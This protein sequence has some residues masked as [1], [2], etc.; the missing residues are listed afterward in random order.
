MKVIIKAI[1]TYLPPDVEDGNTL[2]RDN[3][4]WCIGDIEEKTGIFLRHISGP[5]ETTTD[6]AEFAAEKL[7]K[8]GVLKEDI[9]SLILV[10]QSPDYALPS[11]ACILQNRLGLRKSCIAFDVNLGCSGFVYGL[12]ILGSMIEGGL[13]KKGLIVCSERYT[14]YIGKSDRT[15]RPL[16]SDASSAT[17]LVSS[18]RDMIGPF[19]MGTDGSGFQNLI[20]PSSDTWSLNK[21]A[22]KGKLYMD[23]AKVFMF[24]MATVPKCVTALLNKAEKRIGDIDLFI[25]HQAS[26][27]VMDNV[28]RRLGLPEEKVFV[29]YPRV[30]NTVS[31]SIPIA[32]KDA[33][34]EKRLKNGD[35]VML[36]GFGVGYSWGACLVIWDVGE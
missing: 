35:K 36:I 20:V 19:E 4:T 7:F 13:A 14:N 2:K 16:F 27:L 34:N 17:L 3:P 5:D 1:E 21:N 23:G 12:A 28:I 11:C 30:G 33:V 18:N 22:R 24:T 32:L 6:M 10:T 8:S 26:K 9:D 31:A 29:N 25:F 15:C